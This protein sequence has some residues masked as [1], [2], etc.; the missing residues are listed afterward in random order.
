MQKWHLLCADRSFS[1]FKL[2]ATSSFFFNW[3]AILF[4]YFV[5]ITFYFFSV[6]LLCLF[7]LFYVFGCCLS[8]FAWFSYWNIS[9]LISL[10]I[11]ISRFH[12]DSTLKLFA[13]PQS[14][15]EL[16]IFYTLLS[17]FSP[18]ATTTT[19]ADFSSLP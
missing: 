3:Y 19:F 7:L 1:V 18:C 4:Y 17:N 13:A 12:L 9:I 5:C 2:V 8:K 14:Q 6:P 15:R 11:V 16:S 10:R